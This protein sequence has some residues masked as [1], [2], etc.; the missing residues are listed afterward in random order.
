MKNINTFWLKNMPCLQPCSHKELLNGNVVLSWSKCSQVYPLCS[1]NVNFF[2]QKK[3]FVMSHKLSHLHEGQ[4]L[5]LFSGN[6][7]K[8][9]SNLSSAELA[10]RVVKVKLTFFPPAPFT[11]SV[12][13]CCKSYIYVYNFQTSIYFL[14]LDSNL[15]Y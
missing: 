1:L 6:D 11:D 2:F 7:K 4:S 8:N 3:G 14:C 12:F 13:S 5:E 15:C 9:I 10:Q